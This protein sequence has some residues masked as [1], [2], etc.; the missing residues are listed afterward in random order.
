MLTVTVTVVAELVPTNVLYV[1]RGQPIIFFDRLK[2][3]VGINCF[4]EDSESLEVNGFNI[5][6]QLFYKA[7]DTYTVSGR[8][9]DNGYISNST[10]QINFTITLPKSMANVTAQLTDLRLNA[11]HSNGGY[12]FGSGYV[13]NGYNVLTDSSLTVTILT[14]A[15]DFLTIQIESATAFSGVTNNTPVSISM[16]NLTISFS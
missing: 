1:D 14:Q 4:P 2:N 13:T 7:G 3:S 12:V 16:E 10:K 9:V 5:L 15:D 8:I 6:D 11:R